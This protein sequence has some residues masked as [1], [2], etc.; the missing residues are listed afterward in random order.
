[1]KPLLE[2]FENKRPEIVFEW[3]DAETEGDLF[4]RRQGNAL[5][6]EGLLSFEEVNSRIWTLG[7]ETFIPA[8]ASRLINMQQLEKMIG[9][10]LEVISCGANVSFQDPETFFGSTGEYAD[11]NVA[12]IPD[13]I[14]NCGMTRVFAYLMESDVEIT[15]EAIFSDVSNT[16]RQALE[17]AHAQR[18]LKTEIAKTSFEIA[19]SQLL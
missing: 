10:G 1:M 2:K 8:A 5:Y 15:D 19:I 16:I 4:F 3:K 6:P 7:A 12:V 18:V 11:R 14:A 17:R 9:S 13:F